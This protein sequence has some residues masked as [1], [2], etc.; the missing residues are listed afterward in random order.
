MPNA[1]LPQ[2]SSLS[3]TTP[4]ATS[5]VPHAGSGPNRKQ[6]FRHAVNDNLG[7]EAF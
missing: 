3:L 1:V 6:K 4:F 2:S 7:I 5:L